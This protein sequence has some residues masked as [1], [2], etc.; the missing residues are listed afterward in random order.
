MQVKLKGWASYLW[1]PIIPFPLPNKSGKRT[2]TRSEVQWE[3]G[4]LVFPR[5]QAVTLLAESDWEQYQDSS[6]GP[7]ACYV[8]GWQQGRDPAQKTGS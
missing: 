6:L 2:I 5:E 4:C 3:L 1:A 7:K 8:V